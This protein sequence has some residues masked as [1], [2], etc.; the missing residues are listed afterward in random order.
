MA[1]KA[2]LFKMYFK[3]WCWGCWPS[4]EVWFYRYA[5]CLFGSDV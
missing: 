1:L 2:Q 4:N 3:L 5:E